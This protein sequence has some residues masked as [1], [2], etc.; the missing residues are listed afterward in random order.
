MTSRLV[1]T[2]ETLFEVLVSSDVSRAACCF[3]VD[4][5]AR[6]LS[7]APGTVR[8]WFDKQQVPLSYTFDVMKL[9]ELPIDYSMYSFHK[10]DQFFTTPET[11][12]LCLDLVAEHLPGTITKEN[13][14]F[15]EPAAGDGVFLRALHD[16]GLLA[17]DNG[18][19]VAMDIEPRAPSS[20]FDISQLDF[21]EW[22]PPRPPD[23]GK[24]T[25]VFGNPPFGN[26]GNLA[27]RF[28]NHAFAFADHVAFILPPLFDS[29]G[30][31]VPGKRVTFPHLRYS[32][33]LP[34]QLFHYPDGKR[35]SIQCIFQIWSKVGDSCCARDLPSDE[36][37][38]AGDR[39][40]EIYSLSDGGTPSSTRNR[41]R[42]YSCD[43]Y[44]PST[45]FGR[46]N[47]RAYETFEDLPN[48]RGYGVVFKYR[49]AAPSLMERILADES[50]DMWADASFR[51]TNSAFN[52]RRST[53]DKCLIA[54]I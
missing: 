19:V 4:E 21:L 53:I 15:I 12:A 22:R 39:G 49:P 42:L 3:T 29:D 8:R 36:Y 35:A 48:R 51:S 41:A 16:R 27:L 24:T 38:R 6:R 47:M 1:T 14:N 2:R 52:L 7:L 31:G 37:G 54:L 45:C 17:A 9:R 50:S 46:E 18:N 28:I 44:L 20:T 40:F 23:G 43:L 32:G 34:H 26:R 33:K 13:T 30:K 11:A 5:I 10:K 25:V